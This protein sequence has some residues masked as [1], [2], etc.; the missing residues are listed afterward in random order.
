MKKLLTLVFILFFYS[1]YSIETWPFPSLPVSSAQ[2]DAD[3]TVV[4]DAE[5]NMVA[6]W[7][8]N[9][10]VKTS[11]LPLNGVWSLPVTL[12]SCFATASSPQLELDPSGT[13]IALWLED[14]TLK[15][16]SRSPNSSWQLSTLTPTILGISSP[17]LMLDSN[18]NPIVVRSIDPITPDTIPQLAIGLASSE[19]D[20]HA[21]ET[22]LGFPGL[23]S[24]TKIKPTSKPKPIGYAPIFKPNLAKA[25]ETTST[26]ALDAPSGGVGSGAMIGFAAG[27]AAPTGGAV[28]SGQVGIGTSSVG[29]A[30]Q[31]QCN[32]SST[33][34]VGIRIVTDASNRASLQLMEDTGAAVANGDVI[35]RLDFGGAKDASHTLVASTQVTTTAAENWT[36]SATG[37]YMSFFTTPST[38][39]TRT[40]VVRFN[41]NGG[42]AIGNS[43]VSTLPP[44]SGLIVSGQCGSAVSSV[45]ANTQFQI[46]VGGNNKSLGLFISGTSTSTGTNG[47]GIY[48]APTYSFS[49]SNAL[50]LSG[51]GVAP[52][53]KTSSGTLSGDTAGIAI[54][55]SYSGNLGTVNSAFGMI[56]YAGVAGGTINNAYGL[57]VNSP[58]YGTT[59]I[60]AV[61]N[62]SDSAGSSTGARYLIQTTGTITGDDTANEFGIN[63]SVTLQPTNNNRGVLG[64]Y[65]GSKAKTFSTNTIA[66]AFGCY[67]TQAYDTSTG[68]NIT[69]GCQL[70]VAP[71]ALS[72]GVNVPTTVYGAYINNPGL[73]STKCALYTDNLS[74]G[75]TA[76]TPPTNGAIISGRVGIGTATPQVSLDVVNTMFIEATS[77]STTGLMK[78]TS[79]GS[80]NYFE[81]GLTNSTGSAAALNFTDMN[82]ANTWMTIASNGQVGMGGTLDTVGAQVFITGTTSFRCSLLVY[83]N[84][85]SA[86][87]NTIG[88]Y[89][90]ANHTPGNGSGAFCYL[91]VPT[92][93]SANVVAASYGLNVFP[94]TFTGAGSVTNAYGVYINMPGFGTNKY[95]MQIT[96]AATAALAN[97]LIGLRIDAQLAATAAG[98]TSC[99]HEYIYPDH[100]GNAGNSIGTAYGL[101]IDVGT[102]AGTI[103]NGYSMYITPPA[104]GV[105]KFI[106]YFN[107]TSSGL[108]VDSAGNIRPEIT[109]AINCGAAGRTWNTVFAGTYSTS[110]SRL[111]PAKTE[112]KNC[113]T[114]LVRGTGVVI[115]RGEKAD[116]INAWC[117]H[118]GYHTFEEI[119]H[120][121]AERLKERRP[122]PKIEFLG[123]NVCQYSG[124]SRGIQV[125]FCYVDGAKDD[126]KGHVIGRIEN[127]TYL[128]DVEYERFLA[129]PPN[130]RKAF[131]LQLGQREWDAMEEVRLMEEECAL[132]QSS[133]DN[134]CKDWIG[135][136]LLE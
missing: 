132:L 19:P 90:I 15:A 63:N 35:G 64:L 133:L 67:I 87:G 81:S 88:L 25:P 108:G 54:T 21:R 97:A 56:I 71:G 135:T 7:I 77:S 117:T 100:T 61:F 134:L 2:K 131:I 68:G 27:T 89:N 1:T 116:Y 8:E 69:T 36:A 110:T 125:K 103:T 20:P 28:I 51:I 119:C 73:G 123:M 41:Q 93:T 92:I 44:A 95:G 52:T 78:I 128:S 23:F 85:T 102:T 53:F 43:F 79:T 115:M 113:K 48:C 120:L 60:G 83:G 107:G 66:N 9:G 39:T 121:S 76:T 59:N 17:K 111:A 33:N 5:G 6:L 136:N 82:A 16:A 109:K 24:N 45:D 38:T 112:C 80:A 55:T 4:V 94:G 10:A 34:T 101:F 37:S 72:A 31:A 86:S 47:V 96:G 29:T 14:D 84:P 18:G 62:G 126:P 130:E 65:N 118:C 75:Y 104:Y 49:A 98:L 106:A 124:L 74:V 11:D 42:V 3:P 46:S 129:M 50:S 13:A 122:A 40:E 127:S 105:N 12:S 30:V 91:S 70:Y 99:H 114:Q 26:N 32:T 58:S 22:T 57:Y